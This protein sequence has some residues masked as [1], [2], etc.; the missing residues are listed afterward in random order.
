MRKIILMML[1]V[2]L[3]SNAMAQNGRLFGMWEMVGEINGITVRANPDTIESEGDT[4]KFWSM[5]D[6]RTSQ[7][8]NRSE[9]MSA[10]L[11]VS[12]DCKNV[13]VRILAG[14]YYPMNWGYGAQ[15]NKDDIVSEWTSIFSKSKDELLYNY[16]CGK[17]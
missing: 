17:K 10:K 6:Y 16:A 11:Q 12:F 2:A 13:K 15:I 4:V 5:V 3:S 1:L 8:Y 9:F 14:H 7:S